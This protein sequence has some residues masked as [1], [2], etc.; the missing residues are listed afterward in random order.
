MKPTCPIS[1]RRLNEISIRFGAG[2]VLLLA[3]FAIIFHNILIF[4][5]LGIDFFIRGFKITKCVPIGF[6]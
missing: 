3:V 4:I 6:T 2:F 5:L 1:D